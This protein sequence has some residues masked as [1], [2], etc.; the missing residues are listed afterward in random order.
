MTATPTPSPTEPS[1]EA[2]EVAATI[3]LT[4]Q[5]HSN[6]PGGLVVMRPESAI[7]RD[8]ARA[9]DTFAAERVAAAL[10]KASR[11]VT[12]WAKDERALGREHTAQMMERL[13]NAIRSGTPALEDRTDAT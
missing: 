12:E 1:V 6:V 7:A 10:D 11:K 9:L 5:C 3:K 2:R 8:I 4:N 13:A